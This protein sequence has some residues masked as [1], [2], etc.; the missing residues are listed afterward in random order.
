MNSI[1]TNDKKYKLSSKLW[2]FNFRIYDLFVSRFQA[3]ITSIELQ[4]LPRFLVMGLKSYLRRYDENHNQSNNET[5][6]SDLIEPEVNIE[7]SL[8]D[9]LLPFQLE[10]IRF[11]I[12]HKGR[13][14]IGDEMGCGKVSS[15][16]LTLALYCQPDHC[17]NRRS[18][19]SE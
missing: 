1:P 3:E 10:G 7:E 11:V 14:L 19:R 8:L 17:F 18:K 12:K 13:A 2:L 16:L 15:K 9:T 5:I 4:E 6:A